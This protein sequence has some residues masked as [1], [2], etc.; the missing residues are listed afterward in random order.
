MT[1]RLEFCLISALFYKQSNWQKQQ[2]SEFFELPY[3]CFGRVVQT[4]SAHT[5]AF[6]KVDVRRNDR[7]S[8]DGQHPL[9]GLSLK[10]W[11]R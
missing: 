10:Q 8:M 7:R 9:K 1:K 4:K 6:P 2:N 11:L 5:H 3:H